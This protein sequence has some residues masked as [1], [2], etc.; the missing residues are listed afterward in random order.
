MRVLI[1][2]LANLG[3]Q[4]V[5]DAIP[6]GHPFPALVLNEDN[7]QLVA[8]A[9]DHLNNEEVAEAEMEARRDLREARDFVLGWAN[10]APLTYL[11]RAWFLEGPG[12]TF[13]SYTGAYKKDDRLVAAVG[14]LRVTDVAKEATP[15]E[16]GVLIVEKW[17]RP[18]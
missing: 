1:G 11:L 6:H 16:E 5:I 7:A 8:R 14:A 18:H 3:A 15:A 10:Y 12:Q 17:R 4:A 13:F 9:L 2:E